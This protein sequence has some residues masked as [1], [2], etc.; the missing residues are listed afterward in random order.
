MT[1]AKRAAAL[2]KLAAELDRDARGASDAARVKDLAGVVR[3]L[4]T[5][6]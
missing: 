3:G 6:A 5:K 4:A 1:G 2:R